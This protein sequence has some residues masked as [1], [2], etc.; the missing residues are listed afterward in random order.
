MASILEEWLVY[1][2]VVEL[3]FACDW[4][5]QLWAMKEREKKKGERER[6]KKKGEKKKGEREKK[7]GE[8]EKKEKKVLMKVSLQ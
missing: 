8:R 3:L 4:M 7:K 1:L 6:E 5:K 2:F